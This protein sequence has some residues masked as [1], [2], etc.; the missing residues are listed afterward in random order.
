[1]TTRLLKTEDIK[2]DGEKLR[3]WAEKEREGMPK[4]WGEET[5]MIGLVNDAIELYMKKEGD[6][7]KGKCM[8]CGGVTKEKIRYGFVTVSLHSECHEELYCLFFRQFKPFLA[9]SV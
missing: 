2:F 4:S 8:L 5:R 3:K 6:L 9:K 1:M 7:D